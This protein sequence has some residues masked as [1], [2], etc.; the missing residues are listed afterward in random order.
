MSERYE[1]KIEGV[2]S[3]KAKNYKDNLRITVVDTETGATAS[4]LVDPSRWNVWE[5]NI[6]AV[7]THLINRIKVEG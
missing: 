6:K 1:T 7:V 3:D 5:S 2:F 4:D